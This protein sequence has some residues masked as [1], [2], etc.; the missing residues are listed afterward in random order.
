[1]N[2]FSTKGVLCYVAVGAFGFHLSYSL[3]HIAEYWLKQTYLYIERCVLWMTS[4]LSIH[5]ILEL[6]IFIAQ[7]HMQLSISGRITQW[8]LL[9]EAR[10]SIRLLL[11]KNH[12]VPTHSFPT[13]T[14][15]AHW[16]IHCSGS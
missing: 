12:P 2:C 7:L 4:L 10:G 1:E 11:T 16:A 14:M 3:V 6:R 15:V 9:C 8:L 5:R 13:G